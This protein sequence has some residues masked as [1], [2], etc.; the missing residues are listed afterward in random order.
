[1]PEALLYCEGIVCQAAGLRLLVGLGCTDVVSAEEV[2]SMLGIVLASRT[3][4]IRKTLSEAGVSSSDR[5]EDAAMTVVNEVLATAQQNQGLESNAVYVHVAK[6]AK[7]VRG[8]ANLLIENPNGM[9]H[10]VELW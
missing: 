8:R 4:Q 1:M 10:P 9:I 7:S 2:A 3:D 6:E 5:P